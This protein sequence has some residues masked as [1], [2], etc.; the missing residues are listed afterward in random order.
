MGKNIYC[1]KWGILW[2]FSSFG[3][4]ILRY[5]V[6][7]FEYVLFLLRGVWIRIVILWVCE[8]DCMIFVEIIVM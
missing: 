6:R 1:V 7:D 3:Y 4:G 5:V 8:R 2:Y